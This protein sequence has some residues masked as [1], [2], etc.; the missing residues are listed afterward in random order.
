MK[1]H[2]DVNQQ[3]YPRSDT[4]P[5]NNKDDSILQRGQLIGS[6]MMEIAITKLR[7]ITNNDTFLTDPNTMLLV[8]HFNRPW[9]RILQ[10]AK[11][12]Q[13]RED[14]LTHY[15]VPAF[16]GHH[17]C[18]HWFLTILTVSTD[19]SVLYIHDTLDYS[20][21]KT[22]FV[23]SFYDK[24][25]LTVDRIEHVPCIQ[26]GERECSPRTIV[27]IHDAIDQINDGYRT[28]HIF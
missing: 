16:Y 2:N 19:K 11:Q 1:E 27:A 23:Q 7:Y 15:I 4:T 28:E 18:G 17:N 5:F 9:D 13:P 22:T 8:M 10:D 21:E 26:Q 12:T 3:T 6:S 14:H 24:I 20:S 25:G